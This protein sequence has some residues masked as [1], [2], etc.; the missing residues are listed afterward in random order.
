MWIG[1]NLFARGILWKCVR[2]FEWLSAITYFRIKWRLLYRCV[3]LFNTFSSDFDNRRISLTIFNRT[4][5]SFYRFF[6]F[7][8]YIFFYRTMQGRRIRMMGN[9]FKPIKR[10]LPHFFL[11]THVSDR[12]LLH[13]SCFSVTK[14]S[15]KTLKIHSSCKDD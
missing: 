2:Y 14:H 4:L 13:P 1:L 12:R 5:L 15:L 10:I 7:A 8:Y 11:F 3:N 9:G 6:F